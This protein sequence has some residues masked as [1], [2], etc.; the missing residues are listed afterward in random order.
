[1]NAND[2]F[3]ARDAH[4]DEAAVEPLPNSRKI[5]VEGSRP[6]IRVPMREISQT[7]TP[8]S[9]GAEKN[10]PLVVYDTSGPYTDPAAQIDIRSGLAAAA[11]ALDRGARRHASSP[12]PTS[13]TAARGS[14]TP[15]SRAALR[16]AP[17]AAAREAPAPTSRRCTTRGA[18]SSRRRWS[19]SRSARTCS[20]RRC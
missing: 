17:Q 10:P 6:D 12:G 18:A 14:P 19:S 4:V 15:S 11:R 13:R 9:F 8:A 5:Y 2:Q 1:M 20:A 16:P 3:F 7:D